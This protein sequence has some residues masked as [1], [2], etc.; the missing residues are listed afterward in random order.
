MEKQELVQYWLDSSDYDFRAMMHLYEKGDCTWSLFIGHLVLEK[1]LKAYSVQNI[2]STPPFVHDL[3][4]LADRGGLHLDEGQKD[5]L[6]AISTFNL[7]ARYDDY[8]MEFQRKCTK[9]F[10]AKWLAIIEGFREWIKS[11]LMKL[12]ENI[13][14]S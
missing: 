12:Q 10:T 11:R 14:I 8:K 1:L 2:L 5:L 6:D 7:R 9:E 13:L 3:V 4:R